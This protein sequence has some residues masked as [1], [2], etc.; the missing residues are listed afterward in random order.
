MVPSPGPWSGHLSPGTFIG[1]AAERV[2]GGYVACQEAVGVIL[3]VDPKDSELLARSRARYFAAS[4][5]SGG[6]R[7]ADASSPV[8]SRRVPASA[9]WRASIEAL[10]DNLLVRELPSVRSEAAQALS[11]METSTVGCHRSWARERRRVEPQWSATK[12]GVSTTF[13]R[14]NSVRARRCTSSAR[15][16]S[17]K[18]VRGSPRRCGFGRS[19]L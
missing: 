10:L 6:N 5:S 13:R 15:S 8:G 17:C 4:P 18:A 11:K 14:F 19:G 2:V 3:R 12:E 9:E 1:A 7:P 16:S